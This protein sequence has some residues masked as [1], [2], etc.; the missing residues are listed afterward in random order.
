MDNLAECEHMVELYMTGNPCTHW[1]HYK[2]Y[3]IARVKTLKRLDGEDVTKS[4]RLAAMQHFKLIESKLRIAAEE[5]I[6]K[7]KKEQE[8]GTAN[9][10]AYTK[11]SRVQ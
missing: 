2:D 11:E 10:D 4:Q 6:E 8:E 9:P 1:E 7:K 5:N 3:V